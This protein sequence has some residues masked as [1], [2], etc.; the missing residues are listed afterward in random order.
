MKIPALVLPS[1][2][3]LLGGASALAAVR[4]GH[5]ARFT[6]EHGIRLQD[7]A[8]P[9][10]G[11]GEDG[12]TYLYYL[13]EF[14]REERVSRSLDGLTFKRGAYPYDRSGD[15]RRVRLADGSWKVFDLDPD[16]H[17]LMSATSMDGRMFTLESGIRMLP[18]LIDK[19]SMGHGAVWSGPDGALYFMYMGD[20][21][22]DRQFRIA[23]STDQGIRFEPLENDCLDGR[24]EGVAIRAAVPLPRPDGWVEIYVLEKRLPP[25]VDKV[26][27][28][29]TPMRQRWGS[30]QEVRD[31]AAACRV[32]R[33]RGNAS[34]GVFMRDAGYLVEP[35][36]FTAHRVTD[37][38][39]L[40]P[41]ELPDG[42]VRLYVGAR[43]VPGFGKELSV[44]LSAVGR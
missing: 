39:S 42:R 44:I 7:A 23:R 36:D 11:L 25:A 17:V 21:H 2:L 14:A 13:N 27:E 38:D 41:I 32:A 4:A 26:F 31:Q 35:L 15:P 29:E 6:P 18:Q 10:S 1:L 20:V 9:R 40:W 33:Y 34:T 24:P 19:M 30:R 12:Q 5:P 22:G 16:R 8:Q 28:G 37:L 43:I 3:T